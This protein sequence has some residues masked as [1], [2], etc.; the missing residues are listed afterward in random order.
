MESKPDAQTGALAVVGPSST[1]PNILVPSH[2]G[3]DLFITGQ[4]FGDEDLKIDGKVE[5]PISLGNRRLTMGATARVT[6]DIVAREIVIYGCVNGTLRAD[7]RIELKKDSSAMG[8]LTAARIIIEEGAYLQ[9][10]IEIKRNALKVE[11]DP[12][13]LLALAEKDFKL[14]SIRSADSEGTV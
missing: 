13:T 12:E 3:A 2:L 6:G 14:K 8:S 4:I 1:G 10:H 11:K 9:G 5:G 7:D